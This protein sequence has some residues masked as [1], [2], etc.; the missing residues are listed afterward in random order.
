M[1]SFEG[2]PKETRSHFGRVPYLPLAFEWDPMPMVGFMFPPTGAAP[3]LSDIFQGT[4]LGRMNRLE[5]AIRDFP[6]KLIQ[7]QQQL[8]RGGRTPRNGGLVSQKK[9]TLKPGP[10]ADHDRGK[11]KPTFGR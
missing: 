3:E 2:K 9:K 5:R 8:T 4:V 11:W 10:L 6:M 1:G 7:S